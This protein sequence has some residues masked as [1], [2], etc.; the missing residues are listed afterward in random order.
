MHLRSCLHPVR[1]YNKYLG[2]YVW[3]SCGK[4][5][6]CRKRR[7]AK[8]INR[9]ETE[10]K[11]HLFSFFVTLTYDEK[12]LP[13]YHHDT[14]RNVLVDGDDYDRCIP[15]DELSFSCPA[16]KQIFHDLMSY[17]GIPYVR[18]SDVQKFHKRLNKFIHDNITSQYQ[19]FR[20]FTVSEMGSTTLRPHL[21]GIYFVDSIQLAERFVSCIRKN[22][23]YGRSDIQPIEG[24][25]TSYVAQYLNELFDLPS[26]Y[27]HKLLRPFFVCSK[28]PPLGMFGQS[29]E[30]DKETFFKC[31]PTKVV[32]CQ[33]GQGDVSLSAVPHLS[34]VENRLFPR[35]P[36][37]SRVPHFLR[38]SIYRCAFG[39]V[40]FKEKFSDWLYHV[41]MMYVSRP[42]RHYF[43]PFVQ[44]MSI[45]SR[46]FTETGINCLKRL[47]YMSL[48]VCRY[49]KEFGISV[50]KYVDYIDLYY[51][52]K[53]LYILNQFY[54]FQEQLVLDR[55]NSVEELAFC[56][57]EYMYQN[58]FSDEA[59]NYCVKLMESRDYSMQLQE[60]DAY[61][62]ENTKTHFKNEYFERLKER[63]A[64]LYNILNNYRNA[65]KRYEA[66]SEGSKQSSV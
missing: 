4:C 19:N 47:Y 42:D 18:I 46:G 55:K 58:G 60:A 62:K 49:A 9:L 16:D 50:E 57:P 53:E 15:F 54:K 25:A 59:D 35:F 2:E 66:T 29:S 8:W 20:Y 63:N 10:R 17:R 51:S 45:V 34:C 13:L 52:R 27:S 64:R 39:F 56:Y 33:G 65:K 43:E 61:L 1:V 28:R 38:A 40:S 14:K 21:H 26:F 44:Y 36:F 30:D 48:R 11:Q 7:A 23:R 31:S 5:P 12:N 3:T 32:S 41:R 22:W 37:F 24:S 6:E